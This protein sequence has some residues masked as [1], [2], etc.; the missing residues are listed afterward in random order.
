MEV[1]VNMRRC[2]TD[3]LNWMMDV[4]IHRVLKVE[5]SFVEMYLRAGEFLEKSRSVRLAITE[6]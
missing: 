3:G 6:N 4:T 1:Q 2:V 5:N